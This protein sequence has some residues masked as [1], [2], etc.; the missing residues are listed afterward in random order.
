MNHVANLIAFPVSLMREV[1]AATEEPTVFTRA[2]AKCVLMQIWRLR[3][4]VRVL[5]LVTI[6][7]TYT[8]SLS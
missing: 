3:T 6:G 7:V 8:A 2:A 4:M 5:F 1:A